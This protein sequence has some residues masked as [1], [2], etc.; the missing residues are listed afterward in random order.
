[1]RSILKKF[2]SIVQF[3]R[4][5]KHTFDIDSVYHSLENGQIPRNLTFGR[6]SSEKD[7]SDAIDDVIKKNKES[8]Q[9]EVS[10]SNPN[11]KGYQSSLRPVS[12]CE[13]FDR[14]FGFNHF[15]LEKRLRHARAWKK[16]LKYIQLFFQ[17]RAHYVRSRQ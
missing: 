1:M 14:Y 10:V 11:Q 4:N 5:I 2:G 8:K 3:Y 12:N 9:S 7:D 15:C 13:R 17:A 6:S 16:K